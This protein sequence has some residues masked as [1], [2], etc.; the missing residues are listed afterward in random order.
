MTSTPGGSYTNPGSFSTISAGSKIALLYVQ[1]VVIN[2]NVLA[3]DIKRA[4]PSWT[5]STFEFD[6]V[7]NR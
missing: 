4:K 5:D 7:D 2:S 3:Y 1:E 6:V